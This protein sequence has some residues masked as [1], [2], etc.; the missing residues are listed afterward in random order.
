MENKWEDIIRLF[1][2]QLLNAFSEWLEKNREAIG[3][4][5][6]EQLQKQPWRE[7]ATPVEIMGTAMWMFNMIADF[8]VLAG[9]GPDQVMPREIASKPIPIISAKQFSLK[10]WTQQTHE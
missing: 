5:W 2:T 9:I 3:D 1:R 10:L 4:K 6:Y 8:G 7:C